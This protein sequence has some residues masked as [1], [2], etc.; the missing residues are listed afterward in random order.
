MDIKQSWCQHLAHSI[1]VVSAPNNSLPHLYWLAGCEQWD[2]NL[3][4]IPNE[5]FFIEESSCLISMLRLA[6]KED[7]WRNL[8]LDFNPIL[9]WPQRCPFLAVL[10]IAPDWQLSQLLHPF[11]PCQESEHWLLS[12][13]RAENMWLPL[14]EV[15]YNPHSTDLYWTLFHLNHSLLDQKTKINVLILYWEGK[16]GRNLIYSSCNVKG[17]SQNTCEFYLVIK[18][19]HA[20]HFFQSINQFLFWS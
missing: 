4:N 5:F 2:F 8:F 10:M 16:K 9:F 7:S 1:T 15:L 18:Q 6:G 12:F 13:P 17:K 14:I 3:F 20:H 19:N 11:F